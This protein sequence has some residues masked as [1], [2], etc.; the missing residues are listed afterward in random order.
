VKIRRIVV[1]LD[2]APHSR[3]ALAAAAALAGE[4]GAELE[5]LFVESDDMHHL[6]GLPFARELGFSSAAMRPIDRAGLERALEA[7]VREAR[8]ALAALAGTHAGRWSLRVERGSVS[9]QLRAAST[10]ADL[11]VVGVSRWGPEALR[12]AREATATLVVLTPGA[13]ARGPLVAICP[14]AV[15][16]DKAT[17]FLCSLANAIGDGLTVLAVGDDLELAGRW[18]TQTSELLEKRGRK[19]RLEIVRDGQQ[20]ALRLALD[21]LAP[22]VVAIMAPL[23][24]GAVSGDG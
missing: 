12:L 2:T 5:A 7:H 11:T 9:E 6:A 4:L 13:A 22:R 18:C 3:P 16:P 19:A 8:R 15:P 20:D 21:R 17:S 14:I 24:H 1:G 10:E 23:A